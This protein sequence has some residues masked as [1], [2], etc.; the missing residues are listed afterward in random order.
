M[1]RE[2]GQLVQTA[3]GFLFT[4]PPF[5]QLFSRLYLFYRLVFPLTIFFLLDCAESGLRWF[6][7][8]NFF[9]VLIV[10][11]AFVLFQ[12]MHDMPVMSFI[13]CNSENG[14]F[15][16]IHCAKKFY[17]YPLSVESRGYNMPVVVFIW[18]QLPK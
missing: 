12:R 17:K 8:K 11:S 4:Q 15:H 16:N 10:Q 9:L 2:G 13:R 18:V 14:R 5:T 3:P 6:G 1:I 7:I